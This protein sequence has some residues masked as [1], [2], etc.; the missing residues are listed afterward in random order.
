[1]FLVS[2]SK[3]LGSTSINDYMPCV[4]P[5]RLTRSSLPSAVVASPVFSN[6]RVR[7]FMRRFRSSRRPVPV[8]CVIKDPMMIGH[9]QPV[10]L[11]QLY[12][13]S[14]DAEVVTIELLP[15]SCGTSLITIPNSSSSTVPSYR[16]P[17]ARL[18]RSSPVM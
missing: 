17:H 9:G 8:H 11:P 18:K 5:S 7:F 10:E 16:S 12:V 2:G 14:P 4:T 1:M 6:R 15:P 3:F 13:L